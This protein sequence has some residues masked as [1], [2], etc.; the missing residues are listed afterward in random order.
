MYQRATDTIDDDSDHIP[1]LHGISSQCAARK[2]AITRT[3]CYRIS[4]VP[5]VCDVVGRRLEM[6]HRY[7][8]THLKWMAYI[9]EMGGAG[10]VR[11][12]ARLEAQMLR[13]VHQM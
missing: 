5:Y 13:P 1:A 3:H 4:R 11:P 7:D 6:S 12:F 9:Q 8:P 2:Y 10:V